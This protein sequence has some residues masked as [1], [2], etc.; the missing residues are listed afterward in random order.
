MEVLRNPALPPFI[1][2]LPVNNSNVLPL[3]GGT[4]TFSWVIAQGLERVKGK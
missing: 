2:I 1:M 4:V 3:V